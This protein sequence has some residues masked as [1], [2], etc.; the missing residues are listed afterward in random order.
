M[1]WDGSGKK[2]LNIVICRKCA[3]LMKRGF[4]ADLIQLAAIQDMWD[5][6]VVYSLE[7]VSR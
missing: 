3:Q 2:G 5:A 6:G 4:T 1:V 7:R